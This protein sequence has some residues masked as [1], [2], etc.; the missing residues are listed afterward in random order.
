MAIEIIQLTPPQF[1]SATDE[2]IA[3]YRATF[4]L[5]PYLE[6]EMQIA[7]VAKSLPE[8]P[9]R[10]GFRC[11]IARASATEP[12]VGFAYGFAV[13]STDWW[14]EAVAGQMSRA[15]LKEWLSNSFVLAEIAVMPSERRHGIGGQ[16]HDALLALGTAT[17]RSALPYRTAV[18]ST[19]QLDI[20]AMRLYDS[21]GW[22]VLLWDFTLPGAQCPYVVMG[23]ELVSG[24]LPSP[25]QDGYTLPEESSQGDCYPATSLGADFDLDG[26]VSSPRICRLP[27]LSSATR[28][29]EMF[30]LTLDQLFDLFDPLVHG[31]LEAQLSREG[32]AALVVFEDLNPE[33][34]YF[35][36]RTAVAVGAGCTYITVAECEGGFIEH[37]MQ[38]Q[39]AI[40]Y[41][42]KEG[43]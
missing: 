1:Q 13:Q 24:Q 38:R 31:E 29:N 8:Q 35:G 34:L 19:P 16:L 36:G 30:R 39:Y 26:R 18:L 4:S 33:S 14:Y 37:A 5:P 20:Y 32:V 11:C 17:K 42:E 22:R 12:L 6:S 9:T 3:V 23:L 15:R 21:R 40:A 41:Y 10:L 28:G 27:R 7:Q 25:C 43:G 2:I